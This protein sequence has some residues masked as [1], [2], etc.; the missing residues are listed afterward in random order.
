M[1]LYP[2]LYINADPLD[3]QTYL[4]LGR[5]DGLQVLILQPQKS[6]ATPWLPDLIDTLQTAGMRAQSAILEKLREGY[7]VRD[8]ANSFEIEAGKELDKM[9]RQYLDAGTCGK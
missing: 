6:A 8:E 2:N 4:E 9:L 5:Q 7:W 3:A 1:L